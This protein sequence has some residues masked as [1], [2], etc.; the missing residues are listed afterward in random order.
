MLAEFGIPVEE[1]LDVAAGVRRHTDTIATAFLRLFVDKVWRPFEEAGEP[2]DGLTELSD[3]VE[4]LRP[5]ATGA[6]LSFFQMSMREAAESRIGAELQRLA[7]QRR[8]V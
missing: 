7:Q 2:D 8:R 3:A 1:A 6:V 5:L 4:R